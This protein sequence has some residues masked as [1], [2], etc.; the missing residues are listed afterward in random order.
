MSTIE[1]FDKV[2]VTPDG[3]LNVE[4]LKLSPVTAESQCRVR[5]TVEILDYPDSDLDVLKVDARGTTYSFILDEAVI[6]NNREVKRVDLPDGGCELVA[7]PD[8]AWSI[9]GTE[10]GV[11]S[12]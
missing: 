5:I 2:T 10:H 3:K 12:H 11:P 1:S 4:G 8:V 6:S 7:S 9:V